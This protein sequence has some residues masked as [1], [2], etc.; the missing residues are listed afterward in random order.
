MVTLG[1]GTPR[2]EL[3]PSSLTP[4]TQQ[5]AGTGHTL[6]A[7]FFC[8][9]FIKNKWK[10]LHRLAT[11]LISKYG[12][13]VGGAGAGAGA[14]PL[15][16][17]RRAEGSRDRAGEARALLLVPHSDPFVAQDPQRCTTLPCGAAWSLP[18]MVLVTFLWLPCKLLHGC[19]AVFCCT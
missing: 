11:S 16:W 17:A 6:W 1:L 10:C 12:L 3:N 5:P 8:L 9:H 19:T 7:R 4:S 13:I 15:L 14:V 18:C 2:A